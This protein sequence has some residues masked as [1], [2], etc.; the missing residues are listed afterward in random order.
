MNTKHRRPLSLDGLRA[1]EAVARRLSFSAAATDLFLTQSAV[2]RQIKALED[3]LGA[4][5]F[6][7]GTR[8]V[9]IT[10]AGEALRQAVLPALDGI[11]RAARQI[12]VSQGRRHVNLSTFAS[13]ATLWLMP[14]LAGFQQQHPDI[15]IRITATD[16]LADI[17]D[18]ELDLALRYDYA[19]NVPAG[20]ELMFG[21][22]LTPV[23]SPWLMQQAASGQAPP[24]R[25]AADLARHALLEEDDNRPSAASLSWRRW[26]HDHGQPGL[27]P[28][29]WIYLNYTHQQVQGALAGQGL[30]LARMALV[31]D[32]LARGELV[33]PFGAAGRIDGP[34]A[35]W[36]LALPGARLRPELR[37][38]IAWVRGEAAI[39][40]TALGLP[41]AAAAT[42]P[43]DAGRA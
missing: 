29:R 18:P 17:D 38:F 35:Y 16:V 36:L 37:A 32:V 39:T 12:R 43:A 42:P 19:S 6:V 3:E 8:R 28:Q 30:A 21:E 10:A 4:P 11:D 26:L 5:L 25:A 2:S 15:D 13:F 41:G 7:R 31:H 33:E 23:A 40:R 34:A 22:R 1:F 20:A 27:E 24:L 14:R 9:E